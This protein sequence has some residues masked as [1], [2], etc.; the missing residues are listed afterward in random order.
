MSKTH[1]DLLEELKEYCESLKRATLKMP[2]EYS[3][4]LFVQVSMIIEKM[5]ELQAELK[6]MNDAQSK[7][8]LEAAE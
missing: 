7:N 4:G 8:I 5:D 1:A 3:M 2:N 6:Q